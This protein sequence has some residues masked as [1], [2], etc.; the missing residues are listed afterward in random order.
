MTAIEGHASYAEHLLE[1]KYRSFIIKKVSIK[2]PVIL[3][4]LSESVFEFFAGLEGLV[5]KVMEEKMTQYVWGEGIIKY[6][7]REKGYTSDFKT[8]ADGQGDIEQREDG[9]VERDD[10][11]RGHGVAPIVGVRASAAGIPR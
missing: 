6:L 11:R 8:H 5:E 9:G 1:Q 10:K 4:F 2:P 7:I 3:R